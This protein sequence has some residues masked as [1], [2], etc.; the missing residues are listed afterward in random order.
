MKLRLYVDEPWAKYVFQTFISIYGLKNAL[1]ITFSY[2]ADIEERGIVILKGKKCE[3]KLIFDGRRIPISHANVKEKIQG[4][5]IAYYDDETPAISYDK[6]LKKVYLTADIIKTAFLLLS[7]AEEENT[8][9][10]K[11]GRFPAKYS[12]NKNVEN[13][14]VNEYFGIIFNLLKLIL[15]DANQKRGRT[16]FWPNNAPY[17]VCLT[18]DV[19]NVY[20]WWLKK[21]LSYLIRQ[22]KIRAVGSSIGRKEYW[23]FE[24][25]MD[26]EGKYG[27]RS[28]FFFLTTRRDFQPRYNLR[29]VKRVILNL[30][31]RGWE[32]GLHTGFDSYNNYE[33]ILNEKRKIEKI[34]GKP[35]TGVRN[36]YLRFRA[37]DTWSL[38]EKLG[39]GYDTTLG[40]RETVGFRAGIIHPYFP[41]DFKSDKRLNILELPMTFMDSTLFMA[42][43]SQRTLE[44]LIKTAKRWGGL[45]VVN[46]HQRTFDENDFQGYTDFYEKMLGIFKYD[47]A[48]IATCRDIANWWIMR[49]ERS[50]L[51]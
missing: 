28:T 11:Y 7:R 10:D 50:L 37:P 33:K 41:Y 25:I 31:E 46:W 17:A 1:D 47:G 3:K 48:Y 38:Q 42:G 8:P 26:L 34:L 29:R 24:K 16:I 32:I 2:G 45:I 6:E 15:E 36:H 5:P 49:K 14:I 44:E 22:R 21:T 39:F 40:F 43:D 9:K 20:K 19:D 30:D 18:H 27:V 13:P 35:I 12:I 51:K 4:E 23:N